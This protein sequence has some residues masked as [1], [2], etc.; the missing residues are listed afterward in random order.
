MADQA[1]ASR[2]PGF[3]LVR[4]LVRNYLRPYFRMLGLALFFMLLASAM[5]ALFAGLM[6]PVMD[7][8]FVAG[9]KGLILPLG[10]S[11]FF[12]FIITGIATY[13]H[14]VIMNKIGQGIVSDIQK[15][16][17]ARFML[18]DLAF[19]QRHPSGQLL[20]RVV[21][22]VSMMRSSVADSLTGIGRSLITLVFLIGVMFYQDWKLTLICLAVFPL[23]GG[24]L[25]Y[26]GKRLRKISGN[27]QQEIALLSSHL[28][29]IFQGIRQVK[30]FGMETHEK[31]RAADAINRVRKLMIK[32]VRVGTISVPV[33]EILVGL[34]IFA[35]IVYGGYQIADGKTTVG[36]L[37]SFITAFGL[38]FEPMR[39]LAKL[40]NTLQ[41]GLGCADRVFDMMDRE[42]EIVNR[43]QARALP[44]DIAPDIRF[45]NVSFVYQ[46]SD[47]AAL[48]NISFSVPAGKVTALV[49]PSGGGKSTIMNLIPRFYDVTDGAITVGGADIR[50]L[51]LESLR[52]AMAMVSQDITIFD[53]TARANIAYGRE[54]ASEEDIIAAARAAEADGFIMGMPDGYDTQLGEDGT[55]LSGGQR[56]RLAIARAI[57]RNAPILLLDE[58]T[59][60]LDNEAEQAIRQSLSAL[61]KGRTTL[62][63]A[64]R[65]STVQS[66]DQIIVLDR[67]QIVEQGTHE[68]L[69]NRNGLYARMYQAGLKE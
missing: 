35:M 3:I 29:Q 32:A 56:Q 61:Q 43:A 53:D 33:N 46:D 23:A 30:A 67:G 47:G 15:D 11:V 68:E 16:L 31:L 21:N 13:L 58:A 40:N 18:L 12:C 38:A 41:M 50:D 39:R 17:F 26:V 59:S 51:T 20:S 5:T 44:P 57:L 14:T 36:S 28:S 24:V 69:I 8:V 2:T 55:R 52:G 60:A 19:F 66:A 27:I 54:G 65:L 49:G 42:P 9:Q 22:D 63:I 25:A 37:I 10:L 45:D 34:A 62:V 48:R 4:R 64:H 1:T 6:E 7:K